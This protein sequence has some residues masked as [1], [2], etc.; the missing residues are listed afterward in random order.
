LLEERV[1]LSDEEAADRE[2]Q[3]EKREVDIQSNHASL[4]ETHQ[5]LLQKAATE[6][7]QWRC[8]RRAYAGDSHTALLLPAPL[9]RIE[10]EIHA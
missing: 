4:I 3:Y 2:A 8:V 5:R 9:A 1:R 6:A 7:A 10:V